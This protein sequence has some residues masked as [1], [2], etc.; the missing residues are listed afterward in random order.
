MIFDAAMTTK[1]A[2]ER[3]DSN[4]VLKDRIY[5]ALKEA[6]STLPI[7]ADNDKQHRLD[8]RQ[9]SEKL[10]VSRTPVREAIQKLEWQGLIAVRPRAGLQITAPSA[11]R[12]SKTRTNPTGW[13]W[14]SCSAENGGDNMPS[15]AT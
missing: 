4:V 2:I 5:S 1:L 3:L 11:A 14:R 10:G 7:Y 12:I 15:S 13:A 6:I 8:E 9:L